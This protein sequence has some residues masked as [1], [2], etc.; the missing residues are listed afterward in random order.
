MTNFN[1]YKVHSSAYSKL[2]TQPK[3]AADKA[4][5]LL[6]ATTK[7]FLKEI[8]LEEKYGRKKEISTKYTEKG[9]QQEEA[10]ITLYCRF[11]KKLYKKN[12]VRV[13]NDFITGEPDLVDNDDILKT[14]IGVDIK[15]SWSIFSFP[16]PDDELEKAYEWQNQNYMYLTGAIRW[17]TAFCLVNAPAHLI[18]D[19]KKKAF[20]KLNCP[21][22]DDENDAVRYAKYI[23]Q[24]IQ[25]EK[26]MIFDMVEFKKD[27]PNYDLDIP[28]EEWVYDIPLKERVIE[29][30]TERDDHMIA[31]IAPSVIKARQ[32]LNSGCN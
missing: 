3:A 28:A 29:F 19:E 21:V 6:S 5:G 24:C 9:L 31:S 15:C 26:N 25:I 2:T 30:T 32:Y 13:E 7:T 17:I 18:T 14:L 23:D 22:E 1:N 16:F 27:N 20:Y 11:S 4:A 12:T 8:Y 10:G